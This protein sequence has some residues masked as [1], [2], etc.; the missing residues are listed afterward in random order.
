MGFCLETEPVPQSFVSQL[1]STLNTVSVVDFSKPFSPFHFSFQPSNKD[2]AAVNPYKETIGCH[3]EI[4]ESAASKL[5]TVRAVNSDCGS[6]SSP[7]SEVVINDDEDAQEWW[8]SDL[9]EG[10]S[11]NK[12]NAAELKGK[13]FTT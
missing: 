12:E 13:Y 4:S 11:G 3:Q 9:K 7:W 2:V 5:V 1:E 8:K 10:N 6:T